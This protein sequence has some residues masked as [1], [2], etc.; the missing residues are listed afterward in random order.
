MFVDYEVLKVIWWLFIGVLLAGFSIMDG[1][2]MGIGTLLPFLGKNDDERR[3][4]INAVAPHWDGNQ[5]WFITGGGAIFAAWPL[6]YATSFSGFYWAMLLVLFALFFRPV[7]FDYRSK[8]ENTSWRTTWDFLLFIGSVV[9]PIVCGVAFGNLLQGVPFHF[10]DSL[11]SFYTGSFFAL[12]NPFALV[13]GIVAICLFIMQGANFLCLKSGGG[14]QER[15][16][17]V[18]KYAGYLYVLLFVIAGIW[19][20]LGIQGYVITSEIDPAMQPNPL[21]K[22]VEL[23]DGAW[24]ANFGACPVLWILPILGILG[25]LLSV[26]CISRRKPGCAIVWSSLAMIGTVFTPL[27]AMFPFL[28][29]SSTNLASSLTVWDCTSSHLTLFVMLIVTLIFLPIVLLYT[30]WAYKVMSGKLTEKMIQENSK[31]LY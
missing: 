21:L 31:N 24:F 8:V 5:V 28:M 12:L 10:D 23:K 4:M 11:R 18:A 19:V 27:V 26:C 13:C 14:L 16:R 6:I 20:Y 22:T 3:I 29:P 30:G 2:D 17:I 9:P 15:A 1:Q 7:G 25:A